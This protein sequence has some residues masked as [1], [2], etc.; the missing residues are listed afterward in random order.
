M[1]HG[2]EGII[3]GGN[4][5]LRYDKIAAK[6]IPKMEKPVPGNHSGFSLRKKEEAGQISAATRVV[7]FGRI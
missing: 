4:L 3:P 1:S 5:T 2:T 6:A 7:I